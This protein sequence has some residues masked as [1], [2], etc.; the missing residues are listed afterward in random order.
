MDKK[1]YN[2]K[3]RKITI[4][5]LA[6]IMVSAM[7]ANAS[8]ITK[9]T[10]KSAIDKALADANLSKAKVYGLEVEYDDGAYEVEFTKAS[11]GTEYSFTY[12]TSG[13]LLEK[14]VDYNRSAVFGKKKL[15]KSDAIAKVSSFSG[16]KKSTVS[17]GYVKFDNDDGE[18]IYEVRFS[19]STYDYEYDVHA[20]TGKILSYSKERIYR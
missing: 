8:A 20:R 7:A 16:F 17:D 2:S 4:L 5:A 1:I 9:L 6:I 12:S 10:K 11:S 19:T 13:K 18:A 3:L 15:S 14:S